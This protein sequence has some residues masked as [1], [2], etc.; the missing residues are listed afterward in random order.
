MRRFSF[1]DHYD[2][3]QLARLPSLNTS[4][5][6]R[7]TRVIAW[8]VTIFALAVTL[9]MIF[10][11]WVQ[12]T[13][14]F[15]TVTA[16][17]PSDRLQSLSALV[18]GRIKK[19][20]VRDGAKVKAGD[21]IV[22]LEDNDPRLVERLENQRRAAMQKLQ[23]ARLAAETAE[24][25]LT[26]KQD[27]FEE[28]LVSRLE[29]ESARIKLEEHRVREETAATELDTAEVALSR[30][31]SQTVRAP[32]DGVII[33]VT[34]GDQATW[35]KAGQQLA[36]FMPFNVERAVE[37]HIDGRD[38]PLVHPGRK[39]RLHFE[40]WPV[41]QFSGWPSKAIGTF[42]GE[43]AFVDPTARPGGR[44]RVMVVEDPDAA[45]WP[46]ERFLRLGAKARGWVQLDTVSV[47]YE[48]WRQ[49]NNFPPQL[50]SAPGN[51]GQNGA[52]GQGGGQ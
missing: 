11:P 4:A 40:G 28:G 42:A 3:A 13:S 38:A 39:V 31:S 14:G 29:L 43:V 48:V 27:L 10:T 30:G 2:E 5:V 37:L 19:W 21:P 32:R 25:D 33:E 47:G 49:L 44:F 16:L 22:Q 50:T 46:D 45:P 34:A 52:S 17:E 1:H 23:S 35:V 51:D 8:L 36:S 41:V 24:L 26:R 12:T 15:G 6:P 9:F 20:H 18:P 7:P